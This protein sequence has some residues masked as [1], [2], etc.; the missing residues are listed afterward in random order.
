MYKYRS[1]GGMV[2]S[3]RKVDR[4]S[5]SLVLIIFVTVKFPKQSA[6]ERIDPQQLDVIK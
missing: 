5:C 4:G 6:L 3:T 2:D 1:S